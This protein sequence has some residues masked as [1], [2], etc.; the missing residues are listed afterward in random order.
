MTRFSP[1]ALTVLLFACDSTTI[2]TTSGNIRAQSITDGN[3]TLAITEPDDRVKLDT[4]HVTVHA[5]DKLEN[6]KS[7]THVYSMRLTSRRPYREV[8]K[9]ARNRAFTSG[10]NAIAL[11]DW[12]ETQSVTQ[13][14]FHAFDCSHLH[15]NR[16]WEVGGHK[17]S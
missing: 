10:A 5:L 12:A 7:C 15:G 4:H 13:V 2:S 9:M 11:T 3:T 6:H 14:V 17:P 16:R 1:L 8:V